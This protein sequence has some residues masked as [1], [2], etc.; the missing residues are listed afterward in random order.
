MQRKSTQK[1]RNL[2]VHEQSNDFAKTKHKEQCQCK[3][4]QWHTTKLNQFTSESVSNLHTVNIELQEHYWER[5]SRSINQKRCS[6]IISYWQYESNHHKL[7]QKA[8]LQRDE[9]TMIKCLKKQ[10]QEGK[11]VSKAHIECEFKS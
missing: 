11:S 6:R 3:I 8:N 2:N 10:H 5:K 7:R 1:Q 9:I 4:I